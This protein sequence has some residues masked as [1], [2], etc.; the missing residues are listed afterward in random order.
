FSGTREP[1]AP[2][3]DIANSSN[4]N[5]MYFYDSKSFSIETAFEHI[6]K[7]FR[8][9]TSFLLRN[10]IDGGWVWS[11]LF[12]Y[13]KSKSMPWIKRISP[14]VE[15]KYLHDLFTGMDD[16]TLSAGLNTSFTKRGYFNIYYNFLKE[17]WQGQ[18]FDLNQLEIW[19]GV[20]LF[21]W[22]RLAGSLAFGDSIFYDVSPSYTGDMV[23]G[24]FSVNLQ[25]NKNLN[26]SFSFNHSRLSKNS[27]KLYD[28]TILYS[29]TTYQFNKYF[30]L[31]GILQYNTFQ[32]RML[33]DFLASFTLIPGTVVHA[34]YGGLYENRSAW[35]DQEPL[36]RQYRLRQQGGLINTRR[37]FFLKAS[38]LWRF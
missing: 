4:F 5:A 27:Q 24:S 22:V 26:Q 25:P 12:F 31:R 10:G 37:S 23:E 21:K 11:G 20:Q 18:T 1:G 19:A 15:F 3:Q 9:D 36:H 28:V 30:F 34:G 29:K 13:P 8:M 6:G 38:Y 7:D 32:K 35:R 16:L 33:T 14:Q 17:S 2:Q